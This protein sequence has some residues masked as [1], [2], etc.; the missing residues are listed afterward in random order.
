MLKLFTK[1][2]V[3]CFLFVTPS[4]A[5]SVN[6]NKTYKKISITDCKLAAPHELLLHKKHITFCL[7]NNIY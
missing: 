2:K 1:Q 4:I 5:Q 6:R 7:Y 3:M